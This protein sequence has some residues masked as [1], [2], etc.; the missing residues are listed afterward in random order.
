M[1]YCYMLLC[2]DKSIYT[3]YTYEL[4]KWVNEHNAGLFSK[5]TASRRPVAL[6]WS[7]EFPTKDQAFQVERQIKNW[8]RAKKLALVDGDFDLHTA[9][10]K[11]KTWKKHKEGRA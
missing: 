1:Y 9:L 10:G 11:K 6:I 8:S 2:S 7:D 5:Y 4:E 3:G